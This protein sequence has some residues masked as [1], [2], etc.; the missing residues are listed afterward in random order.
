[1]QVSDVDLAGDMRP[2]F[3]ATMG[4]LRV[5]KDLYPPRMTFS[6]Q[7]LEGEQV[8][9]AGDEKL[10]DM[11][12]MSNIRRI[13]ERPFDAETNMLKHWLK[14]TVEPQLQDPGAH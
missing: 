1:M 8:V 10:K 9:V 6:Y 3:G 12:F 4:D 7:I 14:K 5:V 11:N 13:N 2:T